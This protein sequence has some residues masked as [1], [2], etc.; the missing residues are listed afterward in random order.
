VYHFTS[1][2]LLLLLLLL[3][4]LLFFAGN[5]NFVY[6]INGPKGSLIAKQALP[7][8]R[9]VGESWPLTLERAT[10]EL[11]A[12]RIQ[13]NLCPEF[14]PEVYLFDAS[15]ALI[16]MEYVP[17]PH[18][19]LRKVLISGTKLPKIAD[20][21]SS[22]LA[23]TLYGTSALNLDGGTLR[24]NVAEWSKNSALCAL[25]EQVIFT[26]PYHTVAINHWTTP[27]LDSYVKGV[28]SDIALKVAVAEL[29]SK[30]LNS[31][32][33]LLHG[34]LHSGSIMVTESTSFV[35]DPEFAFYGPMGFDIGAIVANLFLSYFSQSAHSGGDNYAEWVLNETVSL[36]NQ[37]EEKFI[38]LWNDGNGGEAF[39][40]GPFPPKSPELL[41]AQSNYM[42]RIL[43]DSL[44]FAGAK[45]IRR[46]VG[47]AHVA[48]LES[49]SDADIRSSCEKRCL[50]LSKELILKSFDS[51]KDAASRARS[52]YQT[53]TLPSSWP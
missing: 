15:K 17:P 30:F 14:V 2:E 11:N 27:Q 42:R 41:L 47:I 24:T 37:F 23:K 38:K 6:I 7:Y 51:F 20:H 8:V 3:F 45:M 31:T 32:E 9:C 49:I 10:F 39:K 26:D 43:K 1:I 52:I 28:Q 40:S 50:L 4:I 18:L 46:I 21:I 36:Y 34:D 35:I 13:R 33:A 16:V 12:L 5:L 22:F 44:G 29:K 25:S 53:S 48:D 19:I